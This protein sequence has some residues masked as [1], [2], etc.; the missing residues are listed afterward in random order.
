MMRLPKKTWFMTSALLLALGSCAPNN[1]FDTLC[2][3]YTEDSAKTEAVRYLQRYSTFHYGVKRSIKDPE[4]VRALHRPGMT[5][6]EYSRLLDSMGIKFI[7]DKPTMDD[8]ALTADFLKENVELAFDSWQRPWAKNVSFGDFCKY[9][10]PYRNGDEQLHHWRKYFKDKYESMILDSL[11]ATSD[12]R[13][14]SEFL[15]KQLR[16]EVEYGPKTG[17]LIQQ[18]LTVDEMHALHWMGCLGCAHYVT[19]AMRACGIPCQMITAFWRFTECPHTSV[20]IPAVGGNSRAFRIGI[21]DNETLLMGEPKDTMATWATWGT[22][23]EVNEELAGLLD[24]FKQG[25]MKDDIKKRMALPLTREDR[26]SDMCTAY[27]DLWLPVPDSLR[28]EKHLFLCRFYKWK[29]LPVRAG[30]VEGGKVHFRNA[31]I[32]QLYRLGTASADSVST[33]GDVFTLVGD[34]GRVLSKSKEIVRPYNQQGDTVTYKFAYNC[35]STETRLSREIKHWYW[36][37]KRKWESIKPEAA[38]WGYN[39]DTGD[40]KIFSETMRGTY[41]P[42]FHLAEIKLPKW[43]LFTCDELPRP[44]GFLVSDDEFGYVMEF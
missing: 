40:Y 12:L 20:M 15:L 42:V 9:I 11:G 4:A 26:T 19:L 27:K 21:G 10:L 35:D 30:K 43:T 39:P 38:L 32:R 37:K 6:D 3:D 31:S 25:G 34:S 7:E 16:K 41:K 5:D 44:V 36:S 33:F 22:C 17:K 28:G 24:D 13:Q 1:A 23:Y 2:Q 18:P 8:D 14:V 29:W